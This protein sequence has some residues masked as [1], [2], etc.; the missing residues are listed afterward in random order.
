MGDCVSI[1]K[2]PQ[3]TRPTNE[4]GVEVRKGAGVA[5]ASE[6]YQ[7]KQ[8]NRWQELST[9]TPE[10]HEQIKAY[11]NAKVQ[12]SRQRDIERNGYRYDW[13]NPPKSEWQKVVPSK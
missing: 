12:A 11:W 6:S 1:D 9:E 10:E 7:S 13:E 8:P 2:S 4:L 5:P 3:F